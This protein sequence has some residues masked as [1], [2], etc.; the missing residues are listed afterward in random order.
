MVVEV[1]YA[2]H[3]IMMRENMSEIRVAHLL[4]IPHGANSGFLTYGGKNGLKR[5]VIS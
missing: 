3:V 1:K 4:S 2:T 5:L